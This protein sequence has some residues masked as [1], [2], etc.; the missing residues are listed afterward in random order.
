MGEIRDLLVVLL[1]PF[2][3]ADKRL[4]GELAFVP[5]EDPRERG[6]AGPTVP[7]LGRRSRGPRAARR[8]GERAGR[9]VVRPRLGCGGTSWRARPAA[10]PVRRAPRAAGRPGV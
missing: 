8:E 6:R 10:R 9:L 2:A 5:A 7:A 4:C 1:G 3:P